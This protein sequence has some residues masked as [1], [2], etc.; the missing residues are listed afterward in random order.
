[1]PAR[2]VSPAREGPVITGST[3]HAPSSAGNGQAPPN[4][5]SRHPTLL[6]RVNSP[7]TQT[8]EPSGEAEHAQFSPHAPG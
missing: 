2:S 6:T 7:P 5:E 4:R 3:S 8:R 1:M